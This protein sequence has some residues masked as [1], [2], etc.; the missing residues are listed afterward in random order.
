M[1]AAQQRGRKTDRGLVFASVL[2]MSVPSFWIGL[3]LI[4][5]FGVKLRWLPTI[6]Y[7]G[8]S[9]LVLPAAALAM[10]QTGTLLRMMRASASDVMAMEYVTHAYAKGL[11]DTAVLLRH[12]FKNAFTPTLSLVGWLLGT[13]LAGA[14]V[15]ILG[16]L[17]AHYGQVA[18][19]LAWKVFTDTIGYSLHAVGFVPF[20]EWLLAKAS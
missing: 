15:M 9:Y 8:L 19:P 20:L 18:G 17:I 3:L 4:L 1:I 12:V 14:A 7:D 16:I 6:G 11:S 5:L 2:L 10:A 13:L